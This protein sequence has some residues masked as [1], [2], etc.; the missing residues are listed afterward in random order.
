MCKQNK[1]D[2]MNPVRKNECVYKGDGFILFY[3]Y[4]FSVYT[5]V[6]NDL[7]RR[8]INNGLDSHMLFM[9]CNRDEG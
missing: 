3:L 2:T 9:G 4:F 7:F 6:F 8:L 1:Y 5:T